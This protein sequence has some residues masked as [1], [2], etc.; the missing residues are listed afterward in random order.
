MGY[1]S[2]QR[3][4]ATPSPPG[5][6]VRNVL[7]RYTLWLEWDKTSLTPHWD[8]ES[9]EE[10]YSHA[11]DDSTNMDAWENVNVAAANPA[12]TAQLRARLRAF[13]TAH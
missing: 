13:F 9:V 1:G 10:L 3:V 5:Y 7:W 11:G 12:V 6:T 2:L 4:N 8:G